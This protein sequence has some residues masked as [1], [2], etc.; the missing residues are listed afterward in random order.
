MPKHTPP[1]DKT[2]DLG[3]LAL[4]AFV[5]LVWSSEFAF[6]AYYPKLLAL[7]VG[8]ALLYLIWLFKHPLRTP[9]CTSNLTL[10]IALYIAIE[11]L[12]FFQ[13]VN[14]VEASVH[15][16][17]RMALLLLFLVLINNVRSQDI[18]RY[19]GCA[20]GV[21]I[22]IALIGMIQ[23]AGWGLLWMP[24]AGFPSG[25]LGYRN[26]AAMY[27]ILCIPLGLMHFIETRRPVE[28]WFWALGTAL[29][30]T[31]LLCTRTRGAWIGIAAGFS[32]AAIALFAIKT[33]DGRPL[34]HAIRNAFLRLHVAPA[35]SGLVAAIAFL[36]VVPPNMQGLGFDR[37]RPDKAQIVNTLASILDRQDEQKSNQH[38]MNMWR[39]SLDIIADHPLLGVG[40]GNWQFAY[41][42]YDGGDVIFEGATPRRPHNDYIWIASELG[43]PGLLVHIWLLGAVFW[44]IFRQLRT[45]NRSRIHQPLCI[46][47]SLLALS[48]HAIFSFPRERIAVSLL[49]YVLIACI[50]IFESENRPRTRNSLWNPLRMGG[51]AI[52]LLCIA[53]DMRALTFDRHFSRAI[54]AQERNDWTLVIRETSTALQQ[55]VFDAQAL[56]LR[57]VAHAYMGDFEQAVEDTR[58]C[59]NYHPHFINAINNLG[60]MYN[61][62]KQYQSAHDTLQRALEIAP[63]HADAHANMGIAHQGL[64][65]LDASITSL[66]RAQEIE[67]KNPEIRAY[68]ARAHY[69]LGEAR[70][71]Q[72][73][74]AGAISAYTAFLDIWQG[75]AQ[76]AETVRT[77]L[78]ELQI[79]PQD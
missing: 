64:G 76:S 13:A 33:H 55:G 79:Q 58:R 40:L 25:T 36:N 38:R 51:L 9:F 34:Y 7:H 39:H 73:D 27:T 4:L 15:L 63:E 1:L 22:A 6:V 65:H 24:S 29:L 18:S 52:L 41:P 32:I 37:N 17:H 59:L 46:G 35:L 74:T 50:A 49:L 10:P 62:Q 67:P 43:L 14:R 28:A 66:E 72:A 42:A 12:S 68:L 21:G 30:V 23:Y 75:D 31:F 8:L 69:S 11:I 5:P 54:T 53:I 77:R 44:L 48:V 57:G 70:R 47:I 2:F 61:S 26:Y 19:L 78:R 71:A 3:L 60:L 20:A 16:S 56:L 45:L